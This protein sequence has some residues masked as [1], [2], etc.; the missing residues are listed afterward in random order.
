MP[1]NFVEV[2]S[3]SILHE[4]YG[5]SKPAHPLITVIDLK[6][7]KN[8]Q[9]DQAV[10]Y[11]LGL[12]AIFCKQVNG[13]VKY[14]RSHYDFD[15][16]SMM[17]M[18]PGQVVKPVAGS[19]AEV[20][21]GI[22][23]HPDLIY[24]GDL[25]LKMSD[26]SFFQYETNEALHISEVEKQLLETCLQNVQKEYSQNFDKHTN[27]LINN[28]LELILN[29]CIRFYERQFFTREKVHTDAV[30]RFEKILNDYFSQDTLID[31]GIPNVVYFA[32]QMHLSPNYLSDLLH[33]FTGKTT[34][35]HIH[36]QIVEK[37]KSLLWATQ[38]SV[39]EIAYALGFD[40]PSQFTRLF[41][42]KTGHTPRDYR[43]L[44]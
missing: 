5:L 24:Q 6:T 18:S 33:R 38:Q 42:N 8:N 4:L 15:E 23:F 19:F 44:N 43:H 13:L 2:D 1:E 36:L 25:A 11:R 40:Y 41:K 22:F 28:Y 32:E 7:V 39:S 10:A 21:W 14:G 30:Q 37:A 26:Y 16:G 34:Q 29:Y 12:Y 9:R 27:K 31:T 17:F 35:E 20:G 3:V